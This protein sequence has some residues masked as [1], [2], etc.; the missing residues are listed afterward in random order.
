MNPNYH[1]GLL[2]LAHLLIGIDG[3]VDETE[4]L[5]LKKIKDAENIPEELYTNFETSIKTL[6]ERD[7]YHKGIELIN[8]CSKEEKLKTF[9]MLY[10]MSEVDGRVHIKEI[11]LL[12]FSLEMAGIE[13]EDVV[14][15]ASKAAALL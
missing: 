15:A 11:K 9:V 6:K 7:I 4:L 1:L 12:M 8:T 14:N 13:F 5:A 2:H 10:K 3:E